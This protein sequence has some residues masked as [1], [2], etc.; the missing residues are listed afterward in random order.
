MWIASF[1]RELKILPRVLSG[2]ILIVII[3]AMAVLLAHFGQERMSTQMRAQA[4]LQQTQVFM[5]PTIVENA[6]IGDYASIKQSLQTQAELR[7]EI[8]QLIWHD[9]RGVAVVG[10]DASPEQDRTPAWFQRWGGVQQQVLVRPINYAGQA[11]G[12]LVMVFNPAVKNNQLWQDFIRYISFVLIGVLTIGIFVYLVLKR[13][14]MTMDRL[15]TAVGQMQAGNYNFSVSEQG[16]PELRLLVRAFNE[17]NL[18]LGALI[19]TLH[20]RDLEQAEQLEEI[21]AKNFAYQEQHRAVSAAAILAEIDLVGDITYVNDKLVKVTGYSREELLGQNRRMLD[22]GV[23]THAFFDD[24]WHTIM[25]GQVWHGEVCNRTKDGH[26]YWVDT[27][28]V[29]ILH[30]VSRQ[31]TR[32][33]A[34]SFDITARKLA[35]N[36]ALQVSHQLQSLMQ[37]AVEVAI[38]ATDIHGVIT[39][40]NLGAQ[41]MLGYRAEDLVGKETTAAFHLA[42][43][44]MA[45]G[46][47]LSAE[48][49]REIAGVDVLITKALID[50]QE[51]REWTYVRKDG[52]H[53]QVSLGVTPVRDIDGQITGYLGIALDV[54]QRKALES[55]LYL[56]KER[57]EVTLASIGDAVLTTDAV[58]NV[59]FINQVAQQYTGWTQAEAAGQSVEQI[60]HIINE[61]SRQLVENPVREVLRDSVVVALANHTVLIARDGAEYAIEDSA[62][63]IFMNDGSLL[64]CVLVFHDVTEKYRLMRA[65]QWQAGHDVLTNLPNRALLNDRF[66]LAL[67]GARRSN[68]LTAVCLLDLDAFKP[69]NDVYGH[70]AGD[71]VLIEVAQRLNLAVRGDDTVARLGGDEFVLLLNNFRDIEEVE[72]TLQRVLIAVAQ[73]YSI[74]EVLVTV[75]A[76]VGFSIYPLDDADADTLMR[77]ADQAMYQAKQMGRNRY[78][79]FDLDNDLATRTSLERIQR[80]RQALHQGELVLYYQ[81]KVNMRTGTIQ[82]MEALLRWQHPQL[83]LVPPLEFLP[84][85]EQ[86][87]LIIEIGEWVMEQALQQISVW[88]KLGHA[89]EVSVNIAGLHFQRVDFC[90]RLAQLLARYPDVPNKLL[91]IEILESATIGDLNNAQ[92]TIEGCQAS[93]VRVALDDFG[94]GYSS[95]SYLKRLPADVLKIDQSFVRDMLTDKSGMALVEA[96]IGLAHVFNSEVIAEGVETTEHGIL[97]LRLGCDY[98]QGYG[99]ARPMPAT[100]VL[101]WAQHWQPDSK[102]KIWSHVNWDIADFPLLVAQHDHLVWVKKVVS[103]VFNEPLTLSDAELVDHHNCRFGSWYYGVGRQSYGNLAEFI[104]LEKVHADVHKVGHEIVRLHLAGDDAA[105]KKLSEKLLVL[106]DQVLVLL[107]N[108]QHKVAADAV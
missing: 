77:H 54:T 68:T 96:V 84:L 29:P 98:G 93:G 99:I 79:L 103:S 61:N 43:E 75:N 27:T 18:R 8:L 66:S 12:E 13:S 36:N 82:G 73:P 72:V 88:L 6:V 41:H 76:S 85:V 106:K 63:P 105:A 86:T 14:V 50:G 38:I 31:P 10:R 95:L 7:P 46:A 64:G 53:I 80:V 55:A 19:K 81:P 17:G 22:S 74:G 21:R 44:V 104:A 25:A 62:A 37:A 35:E 89:W 69:I 94:T 49:G 108:L 70:E 2:V 1:W 52:V 32:Y 23:H 67:A 87:D 9:S 60:F 102:W 51:R 107:G 83:G 91:E 42:E 30:E 59:T 39:L 65:V 97:L 90:Q 24:L 100:Q 48:F 92:A 47:V 71:A 58:G 16:S 3:T 20:Q 45:Y 15:V 5:Q 28:I 33:K 11:Y 4:M 57:A 40:F 26:L 78:C 101:D 56:E 34:I